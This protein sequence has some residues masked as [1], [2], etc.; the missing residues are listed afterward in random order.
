MSKEPKA[1]KEKKEK[2]GGSFKKIFIIY[3]IVAVIVGIASVVTLGIVFQDKISFAIDYHNAAKKCIRSADASKRQDALT[4]FANSHK[5]V[6]DILVLDRDNNITFRAKDS[7]IGKETGKLE[8]GA[9]AP[10]DLK[11]SFLCDR[12]DDRDREDGHEGVGI[13]RFWG[14]KDD[15]F[16][17]DPSQPEISYRVMSAQ[18]PRSLKA[19]VLGWSAHD[20]YEHGHFYESGSQTVY[21]LSYTINRQTGEKTYFIFDISPVVNSGYY[22]KG[23]AALVMLFFMVYWVLVALYVYCDAKKSRLR[24]AMWGILTLFTNLCGLIMYLIFKQINQTCFKCHAVQSRDN[25]FCVFCGTKM[26]DTCPKCSGSVGK[27]DEY[28]RHCGE[29]LK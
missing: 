25:A 20:D 28:C 1:K 17:S 19:L 27:S 11:N 26:T 4:K 16:M 5:D 29:Q 13:R 24:A 21:S 8:L 2:K 15:G 10:T 14:Q 6:V 9:A 3:F 7:A 23:I 22:V 12:E 18:F